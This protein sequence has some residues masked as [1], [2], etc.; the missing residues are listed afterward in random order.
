MNKKETTSNSN[1]NNNDKRIV[2]YTQW[3]MIERKTPYHVCRY[4]SNLLF[5]DLM[6][7]FI[8]DISLISLEILTYNQKR[9]MRTNRNDM[10]L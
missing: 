2:S 9:F 7:L 8:C 3:D 1:S 5:F 4:D 6:S 10:R